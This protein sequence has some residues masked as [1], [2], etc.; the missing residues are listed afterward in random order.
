MKSSAVARAKDSHRQAEARA[1]NFR[2]ESGE[3][4]EH[5]AKAREYVDQ[6]EAEYR[7]VSE[8]Y[9]EECAVLL[10]MRRE[11]ALARRDAKR[12]RLVTP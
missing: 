6:T 1:E 8:R 2:G 11:A 4:A 3:M 7:E 12:C 9:Q 5:A 10:Q